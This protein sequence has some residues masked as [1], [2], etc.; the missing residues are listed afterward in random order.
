MSKAPEPSREPSPGPNSGPNSGPR[1]SDFAARLLS[2][3]ALAAVS[4]AA[5]WFGHWPFGILV[6]ATAVVASWEW[7]RMV[8]GTAFDSMFVLQATTIALATLGS[9]AGY[10]VPA[11]LVLVVGAVV[12]LVLRLGRRD[13]L[14]GLGVLIIGLPAVCL[15]LLRRDAVL[16]LESVL[17]VFA[18]VWATDIGGYVFGRT[19]GGPKLLPSI[20]PGK[21]WAGAI[22]G[23]VLAAAVGV[24][25]AWLAGSG[26]VLAMLLS[27]VML[28][29]AAEMGDLAESAMKRRFGLK[30][31]S[32]LI[33]GHGGV[34][35]RI[36][37]LMAAA[38]VATL[39][40]MLRSPMHPGAGL[41][42]W[43]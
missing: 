17:F 21:T 19:L 25:A 14:T 40:A 41:L 10:G 24:G 6:A 18:V 16:G 28:S 30:D 23:L 12:L 1:R 31:A 36:D 39:F 42:V 38:V 20:S 15:A 13:L 29:L 32:Q 7:G 35:D 9:T 5:L 34:L 2:G 27:A 22:G 37:G 4:L 8:R 11:T 26:D 43:P 33:P 3:L